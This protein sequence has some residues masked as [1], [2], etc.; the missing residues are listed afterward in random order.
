MTELKPESAEQALDEHLAATRKNGTEW[1]TPY[2]GTVA[3]LRRQLVQAAIHWDRVQQP[4]SAQHMDNF[5]A[6]QSDP[7]APKLPRVV[8]DASA[9]AMMASSYAYTLAAIIG[10]AG[11]RFGPKAAQRLAFI[12]DDLLTNGDFDGMNA[13]VMPEGTEAPETALGLEFTAGAEARAE[14]SGA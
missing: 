8:L 7:E 13:D 11:K 6:R 4:Y 10:D 14:A 3:D 1:A 9:A 2:S 5:E 12:A